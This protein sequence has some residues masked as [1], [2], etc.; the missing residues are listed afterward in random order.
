M[1]TQKTCVADVDSLIQVLNVLEVLTVSLDRLGA[2]ELSHGE[3]AAKEALHQFVGPVIVQKIAEARALMTGILENC[4]PAIMERLELLDER[5]MGYW[6][7]P[8]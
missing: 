6:D 4:D 7:G 1:P 8:K 3:E 2:Y 5:E